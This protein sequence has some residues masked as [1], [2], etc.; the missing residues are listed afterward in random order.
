MPCQLDADTFCS[1]DLHQISTTIMAN[2]LKLRK[3]PR[4]SLESV[5]S[6]ERKAMLGSVYRSGHALLILFSARGR[7]VLT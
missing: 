3:D 7:F 1:S 6:S 4:M 5:R 2:S